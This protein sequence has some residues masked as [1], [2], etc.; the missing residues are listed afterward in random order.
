MSS[1][2]RA[3]VLA[4]AVLSLALVACDREERHGR[5]KPLGENVP[6]G[7]SPGVLYAGGVPTSNANDP[8]AKLYE[9][10]SPALA[11]GQQLFMWMNCVGCHAHG[12]GGMGPPLMDDEWRYGGSMQQIAA[13]IVEGR[14]NGM[15]SFRGKLTDD[16]VWKLAAYVRSLSG[17]QSKDVV[18]SRSDEMST[19]TP[20]TLAPRQPVRSADTAQQ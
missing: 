7:P 2:F 4:A 1:G 17:Q 5:S 11:E 14:P 6:A 3:S 12:G 16:Q 19:S 10:N 15:P 8:R 20:Q 9:N 13:T 18:S